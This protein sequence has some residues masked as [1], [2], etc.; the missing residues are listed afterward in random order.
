M[1]L[2]VAMTLMIDAESI[3]LS[4][5]LPTEK[6]CCDCMHFWHNQCWLSTHPQQQH[7]LITNGLYLIAHEWT[8]SKTSNFTCLLLKQEAAA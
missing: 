7:M 1:I 5:L 2:H 8:Q 6:Y 3:A 4:H